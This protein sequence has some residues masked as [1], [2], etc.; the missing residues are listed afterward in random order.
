MKTLLNWHLSRVIRFSM[1]AVC[2]VMVCMAVLT[3]S[4]HADMLW[5]KSGGEPIS[6]LVTSQSQDVVSFRYG[7]GDG[8]KDV[9]VQREKIK[10]LVITIDEQR[11]ESLAPEDFRDYL[12]YA[13][14]LSAFEKDTYAVEL[15]KRLCLITARWSSDELRSSAFLLL[16]SLCSDEEKKA[17]QR[18]A[19]VFDSSFELPEQ[20]PATTPEVI[21]AD[22]RESLIE[23]VRLIRREQTADARQLLDQE[24]IQS[25][26]KPAME[27]YANICNLEELKSAVSANRLTVAK[28]GQLIRLEQALANDVVPSST[29][30][31]ASGSDW[32][33]AAR[34]IV[35]AQVVLPEFENVLPFDPS[36]NIYRSGQWV[37]PSAN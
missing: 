23:I 10:N 7:T 19:F 24:R 34:E 29:K 25:S 33:V 18:L 17:V 14:E 12:D 37:R 27:A 31:D 35:D 15:A 36:L 21:D 6:G 3:N 26:I 4:A 32:S 28:L 5:L 22:A 30:R 11:M 20:L 8:Q 1:D 16:I 9:Q 13:E 2:V